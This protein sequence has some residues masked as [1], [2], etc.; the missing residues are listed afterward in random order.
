MHKK[1]STSFNLH[2]DGTILLK[3]ILLGKNTKN[4]VIWKYAYDYQLTTLLRILN[5][6]ELGQGFAILSK[7]LFPN[8]AF[9]AFHDATNVITMGP[10][11]QDV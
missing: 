9:F 3:L 6:L 5:I 2:I 1:H 4:N 10:A 8:Q 11:N 7:Q